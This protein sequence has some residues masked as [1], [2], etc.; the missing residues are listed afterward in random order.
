LEKY[1]DYLLRTTPFKTYDI[2]KYHKMTQTTE[3]SGPREPP[4]QSLTDTDVNLSAHPALIDQP[5]VLPVASAQT[6][7]TW[8]FPKKV[9]T[10]KRKV[11]PSVFRTQR[12]IDTPV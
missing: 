9:D 1:G 4:P 2:I 8:I 7:T 5:F 11:L 6:G 12:G 3:S 10:V